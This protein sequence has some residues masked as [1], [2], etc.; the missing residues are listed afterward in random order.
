MRRMKKVVKTFFCEDTKSYYLAE[1]Y[2]PVKTIK[3]LLLDAKHKVL[4]AQQD[5]YALP[6]NQYKDAVECAIEDYNILV[7]VLMVNEPKMSWDD[8][9][10]WVA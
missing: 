8:L 6:S 9:A 2:E 3:E 4:F 5:Y 1:V 7:D 10:W